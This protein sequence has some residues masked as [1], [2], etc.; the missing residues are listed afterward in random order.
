MKPSILEHIICPTC[1]SDFKLLSAY[2][3]KNE[4]KANKYILALSSLV[5]FIALATLLFYT[6]ESNPHAIMIFLIFIIISLLF[7]LIYGRLVRGHLFNR[8]YRL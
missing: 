5:S 3:L 2:K 6:Y 8:E 4:I 1:S 7:E